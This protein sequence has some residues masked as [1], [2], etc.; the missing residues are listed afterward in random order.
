M[1]DPS[2]PSGI[3]SSESALSPRAFHP[4]HSF[5][6][7]AGKAIFL[8]APHLVQKRPP[9][10]SVEWV[11]WVECTGCHAEVN[12]QAGGAEPW[13][14]RTRRTVVIAPCGVSRGRTAGKA[15][16][17]AGG[18]AFGYR[19]AIAEQATQDAARQRSPTGEHRR[20]S[21]RGMRAASSRRRGGRTA[22]A[23]R[24]QPASRAAFDFDFLQERSGGAHRNREANYAVG[25][26]YGVKG[27]PWSFDCARGSAGDGG[28][29]TVPD[30]SHRDV[31]AA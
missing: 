8:P 23:D 16:G 7:R 13:P 25:C 4:F 27:P 17:I 31:Q 28:A 2:E 21:G 11:E 18:A 26:F 29:G 12:E 5:P 22:K 9:R 19:P 3:L 30:P 10:V 1:L 20:P 14:E 24:G 15:A 6:L